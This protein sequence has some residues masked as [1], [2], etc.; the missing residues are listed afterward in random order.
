MLFDAKL[1]EELW[2]EAAKTAN[3]IKVRSPT[4][5]ESSTPWELFTG[6]K[7]DVSAMRV[8]G[9]KAYAHV[10]K[11]LRQKLDAVS[12][13]GVLVG[14]EPQSKAYR[15]L[16]ENG[17]MQ[18]SRDVIFDEYKP[19]AANTGVLAEAEEAR[20][21]VSTDLPLSIAVEPSSDSDAASESVDGGPTYSTDSREE[22]AAAEAEAEVESAAQSVAEVAAATPLITASSAPAP[23]QQRY[24]QRERKPP[25][26]IYKAQAAKTAVLEEPQTYSQAIQAEDATEWRSAMDEEMASLLENGTWTLEQPPIGVRPIPVKWVYKIKKDAQGNIERYKARL[27]AK[28]F[29]QQEGINYTEVF[30]PVSKQ[31]TLRTL[32]AL[33]A[34]D[35]L[36]LHQLDIK[37][38]F[39]NG[40]LEETIY[41][42]QPEGYVEGGPNMACHLHKSLY[43]LK[44]APR[45]WNSK[46][47]QELESMGFTAS[48]AD[49]GLFV[50]RFK[51]GTVYIL[52]YVDDLLVVSNSKS[53]IQHVISRL[54]DAFK[55]RDLGEATYF[56]GMN[57]ER[58]RQA[59]TLK[60]SQERLAS[61]LVNSYGMKESKIKSTPLSTSIKL[62]KA[63]E[64]NLLDK[65]TYTYSHLVGSLLY[66]AT[67]TRPDISQ[68]VGALARHMANPSTEH[69][70][71][72]KG[73]L[74]Y[75]AG[76]LKQG[77][78]YKQSNI[79]VA[80]YCD[81]DYASDMDT[82][83]STTGFV[84][85]LHG[86][87]ISWNSKL[88][89]TVAVS[90]SEAEYMAAAQ[91]VKEGLWLKTLLKDFGISAG[92]IKIK[93]DSQGAIKLLKNPVASLRTKHIDV[94]HHFARER[95]AR[96]EVAFEYC[97]TEAMVADSLTKPLSVKK[98]Q[99]CCSGM[100]L[101]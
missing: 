20:N 83:R 32:L 85:I 71:A 42:Q 80:G 94:L 89:P 88:Q 66:L 41:M 99:F 37:T 2:A 74:R 15:V 43:G 62:T 14:Y 47:K 56:L 51:D 65:D 18:I 52:V 67:C 64:E 17:R 84:Y 58:D 96:K 55:V 61:D 36:E 68:T 33:V 3:Y 35:D 57:I 7:P 46:L 93:C 72:A 81:A 76:T 45:A 50:G 98:F 27:V 16:L 79:G 77:I 78:R 9:S 31:S 82:R 23:T 40:D 101:V 4:G 19:T 28:G 38:A 91:A 95:V 69:W 8:F 75:L 59:R 30:A 5:R 24:P 73:V 54:Q 53:G 12:E 25:T 48:E 11:Q 60:L 26:E 70:A 87:A 22:E 29:M 44:Q 21:K 39:L 6:S 92:P 10:P 90:T 1:G 13:V 63:I 97:S 49:P 100:G 86:G 34:A